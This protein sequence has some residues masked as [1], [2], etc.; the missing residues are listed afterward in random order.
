MR[1]EG[2]AKTPVPAIKNSPQRSHAPE[3]RE[4]M[5]LEHLSQVKLIARRIHE[6]LPESVNL[7][8]LISAGTI[9]L[10]GAIDRFDPSVNVELKTYAEYK[11]RGEILDSLR[12]LDC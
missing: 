4:R 10:I 12:R 11:L 2:T 9:G 7:D 1:A 6:R 8:D 3:E 5:I